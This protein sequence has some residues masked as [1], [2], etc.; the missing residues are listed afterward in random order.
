MSLKSTQVVSAAQLILDDSLSYLCIFSGG[1]KSVLIHEVESGKVVS[2]VT[3]S[4][5]RRI[6]AM[7]ADTNKV[8]V[9]TSP[10]AL[11]L[12]DLRGK[13]TEATPPVWSWEDHTPAINTLQFNNKCCSAGSDLQK[14]EKCER[15]RERER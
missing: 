2:S 15:E 8:V 14:R 6:M 5:N 11:L 3:L 4:G 13:T 9:G 7:K 1:S 12:Y 10:G